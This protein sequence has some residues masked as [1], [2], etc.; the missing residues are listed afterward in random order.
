MS[1]FCFS[2]ILQ[3]WEIERRTAD[4]LLH[5]Q[6]VLW[7]IN[8]NKRHM[9]SFYF[10][11]FYFYCLMKYQLVPEKININQRI[12][13]RIQ[14]ILYERLKVYVKG[15]FC[16]CNKWKVSLIVQVR[17]THFDEISLMNTS[18]RK[19]F[20]LSVYFAQQKNEVEI[21]LFN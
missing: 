6:H 15:S 11:W 7:W 13:R 21:K 20:L 19:K 16:Y 12:N 10:Y 8:K 18:E 1:L 2:W 3:V 14:S 9:C 17:K 4:L 5:V